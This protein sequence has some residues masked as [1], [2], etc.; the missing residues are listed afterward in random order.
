MYLMQLNFL[1][2]T[3][4]QILHIFSALILW[5]KTFYTTIGQY[6]TIYDFLAIAP[7]DMSHWKYYLASQQ[8]CETKKV[9]LLH[10]GEMLHHMHDSGN[11]PDVTICHIISNMTSLSMCQSYDSSVCQPKHDSTW[12]SI[13]LSA[14]PSSIPSI[15]PSAKFTV[16]IPTSIAGQNFL[17]VHFM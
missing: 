15:K 7:E 13:H 14:C 1:D 5:L 9:P 3:P 17:K 2:D 11:S 16:K 8:V 12:N 10:S 4:N 6:P